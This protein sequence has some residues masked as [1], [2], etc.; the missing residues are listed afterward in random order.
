ML[1][2]VH[3]EHSFNVMPASSPL[4]STVLSRPMQGIA[5]ISGVA[6]SFLYATA[7]T[8]TITGFANQCGC[9]LRCDLINC[10]SRCATCDGCRD[11]VC[12]VYVGFVGE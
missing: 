6:F 2:Y 11:D 4:Q 5:G 8:V 7:M 3:G 1:K 12:L 10:C 9:S